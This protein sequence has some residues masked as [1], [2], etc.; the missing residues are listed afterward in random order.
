MAGDVGLVL[1]HGAGLGGFI[2]DGV[3]SRVRR[4]VLPVEFPN[5]GE[6]DRANRDLTLHD[7]TDAV[8]E[9]VEGWDNGRVVLVAHSIGGCVAL[10]VA[11][12]LGDRVAGI[13]GVGAAFPKSG[14]S[15][16]SC[17]SFPR[18]LIMPLIL[19][20]FGTRPPA[21]AIEQG[22]CAD[23]PPD[24]SREVVERF[25][26]ESR[27]L[28]TGKVRYRSLPVERWYVKLTRD[29]D[30]PPPVQDAMIENLEARRVVNLDSGHLPMMSRPDEVA[31]SVSDLADHLRH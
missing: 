15:F 4:P 8:A 21:K 17:L 14:E 24:P 27:S 9:R 26:P 5:R 3:V 30:F 31:G 29:R 19:R 20:A 23:L 7:Y 10:E 11:D 13:L 25:T 22:L 16:I 1:I 28:Y 6:G 18:K 2:W 12:R